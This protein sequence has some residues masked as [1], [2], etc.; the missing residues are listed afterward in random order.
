MPRRAFTKPDLELLVRFFHSAL[1][2]VANMRF[3][4]FTLLALLGMVVSVYQ[5]GLE[6]ALQIFDG[7]LERFQL[8]KQEP[9]QRAGALVKMTKRFNPLSKYAPRSRR[10]FDN[11]GRVHLLAAFAAD[12]GKERK[13]K[14]CQAAEAFRVAS[15]LSPHD[16]SLQISTADINAILSNAGLKCSGMAQPPTR[17]EVKEQLQHLLELSPFDVNQLYLAA[18]IYLRLDDREAALKLLRKNIE[19]NPHF[20]AE[21]LRYCLGLVRSQ[22]DL[23]KI[24]PR[25]YPQVL[26]WIK[27]F[28]GH[29][30][31]D[32]YL[33]TETFAKSL[34]E[35]IDGLVAENKANRMKRRIYRLALERISSLEL[36]RRIDTTRQRVDVL[37]ATMQREDG[38]P[39][40]EEFYA[41]R[42]KL[43]RIP[44]LK[45]VL[46][47]DKEPWQ[48][49]LFA[50]QTDSSAYA[51][52]LDRPDR[53]IGLF[54]PKGYKPRMITLTSTWPYTGFDP[55]QLELYISH[56]NES[57]SQVAQMVEFKTYDLGY[58]EVL[59]GQFEA[60]EGPYVK[61]HYTG[62][63][64]KFNFKGVLSELI[65]VYGELD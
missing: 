46:L 55:K 40:A 14:M 33:W 17:E 29:R 28:Q 54:L 4:V 42:S 12:S 5:L 19:I 62:T 31:S 48:G 16:T 15:K 30:F 26:K 57:Y 52:R 18:L 3:L 7:K 56:N 37:L 60:I 50:W 51:L 64:Q 13:S 11:L 58:R 59:G 20:S 22:A 41:A 61:V 43:I 49:S 2:Q 35:A 65:N 44:V 47:E 32:Y 38:L 8:V 27:F 23:E 25:R 53:T 39:Q 63:S 45:T 24:L 6:G 1:I 34:D 9:D 10:V 36:L 21:Q